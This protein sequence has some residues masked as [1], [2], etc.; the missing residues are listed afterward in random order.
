VVAERAG[1][2][3]LVL[4]EAPVPACG[5]QVWP[6][7]AVAAP[8]QVAELEPAVVVVSVAGAALAG[9][10]GQEQVVARERALV[11]QVAVVVPA[12]DGPQAAVE[13]LGQVAAGRALVVPEVGAEPVAAVQ[14]A[15][16]EVVEEQE[17]AE[18]LEVLEGK[19]CRPE[20]G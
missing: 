13:A 3:V 12:A 15:G 16:T 11:A 7:A 5:I 17:L 1:A 2:G 6:E 9:A 20:N 10:E 8:G 14:A 4:R 19:V 18:E